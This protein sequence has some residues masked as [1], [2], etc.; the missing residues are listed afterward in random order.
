MRPPFLLLPLTLSLAAIPVTA[1]TRGMD[2]APAAF[3]VTD[4]VPQELIVFPLDDPAAITTIGALF[5]DSETAIEGCDFPPGGDFTTLRCLDASGDLLDLDTQ[6]AALSI[7]GQLAAPDPV[8]AFTIDPT[9][10][11]GFAITENVGNEVNTLYRFPPGG[12]PPTHVGTVTPGSF[13]FAG[14]AAAPNGVLYGT[15]A[16][17]PASAMLLRIDTQTALAT[18]V[19]QWDVS[20]G[21][22]ALD[23]DES[24]GTCYLITDQ[25]PTGPV[26]LRRCDPHDATSVLLGIL[27]MPMATLAIAAGGNLV[28]RDDFELGDVSA[29]SSSVP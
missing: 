14:V 7:V 3:A 26:V 23:F 15:D 12:G 27:P 22:G 2:P 10:G 5:P 11:A 16:F 18:G 21:N 4:S 6:T 19:G 13:G 28:F 1:T 9:S 20:I 8:S 17:Q 24:D 25:F 29:W